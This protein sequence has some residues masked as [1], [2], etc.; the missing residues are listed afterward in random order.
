M[1]R[2]FNLTPQKTY[3]LGP[4]P[5]GNDLL[6][7]CY[8]IGYI[9]GD[10]CIYPNPQVGPQ[11]NFVSASPHIIHWVQRFIEAHFNFQ[12]KLKPRKVRTSTNGRHHHYSIYGMTAAKFI[13]F[14]RK[15]DVPRFT[16]K[17]DQPEILAMI[18]GYRK[19]WPHLWTPEN[20]LSFDAGGNIVRGK[21]APVVPFP[22]TSTQTVAA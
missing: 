5:L 17:W 4:P 6:L 20:E 14:M 12:V 10:G 7:C 3:R 19:K 1:A 21:I 11:I 15:I 9:D 13:D 8:L 22:D 18:D 2:N 16:R